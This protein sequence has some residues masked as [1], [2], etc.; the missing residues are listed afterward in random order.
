M[1]QGVGRSRE[2]WNTPIEREAV[3]VGKTWNTLVGSSRTELNGGSLFVTILYRKLSTREEGNA[4]DDCRI[5]NTQWND[6]DDDD[7]KR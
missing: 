7:V 4:R 3:E 5:R 1:I 2:T 6:D